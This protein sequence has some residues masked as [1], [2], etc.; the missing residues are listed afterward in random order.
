MACGCVPFFV[1]LILLPRQTLTFYPAKYIAAAMSLPGVSPKLFKLDPQ[2]PSG[3]APVAYT[4]PDR[5]WYL[6]PSHY[7]VSPSEF[8]AT[9]QRSYF[10]LASAILAHART[11]L[12][13][14]GMARHVLRSMGVDPSAASPMLFVTHCSE[15]FTGDSLLYGFQKLLGPASV[16]DAAFDTEGDEARVVHGRGAP[17][18]QA[19]SPR[20]A[21]RRRD[22]RWKCDDDGGG[23]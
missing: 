2:T 3:T 17:H 19:I 15:D 23:R 21:G 14:S 6:S 16:T 13:A 20:Y 11:H 4:A 8:N 18:A 1:D 22:R 12:S 9:V 10:R 7:G 5:L